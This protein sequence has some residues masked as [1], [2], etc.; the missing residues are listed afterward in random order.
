MYHISNDKRAKKSAQ[1]IGNGMLSCLERKPF[2]EITVAEIQRVSTV[3]RATF[4]RL[5]D[6]TADVIS[7]LCDGVFEQT[8]QIYRQRDLHT[9]EETTSVFI[10]V[11]MENKKLLQ[12]VIDSNR[13]DFI[14][15]SHIKYLA[16]RKED[17]LQ[18]CNFDEERLNYLMTTLTAC[19]AA[20]LTAWLKNGG[21]ETA[22]Q[23]Q[24]HIKIC[25]TALGKIFE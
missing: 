22:Q 10:Q 23:L 13:M 11:W 19:T 4:Y 12:A 18:N 24:Q 6:N 16:P 25:F 15:Q 5:F 9:V 1:L 2:G 20:F 21:H 3:S 14:F 7:Y 17:F 8:E